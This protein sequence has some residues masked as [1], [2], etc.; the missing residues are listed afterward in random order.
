MHELQCGHV[1]VDDG[2]VSLRRV[3]RGD[4]LDGGLERVHG[5]R[6]GNLPGLSRGL[7]LRELPRGH[8]L[9]VGGVGVLELRGGHLPIRRRGVDLRGLRRRDSV[10]CGGRYRIDRVRDVRSRMV[11]V[12]IVERVHELRLGDV[13]VIERRDR[14]LGVLGG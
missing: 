4:L 14:L 8:V 7:E 9:G 5:L 13:P 6:G 12:G 10:K 2:R 11:L 3:R 1:L